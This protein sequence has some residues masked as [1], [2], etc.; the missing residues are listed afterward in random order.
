MAKTGHTTGKRQS[1]RPSLFIC[2]ARAS[3]HVLKSFFPVRSNNSKCLVFFFSYDW[4]LYIIHKC[5]VFAREIRSECSVK[6][7]PTAALNRQKNAEKAIPTYHEGAVL[8]GQPTDFC[9]VSMLSI[10]NERASLKTLLT[11][12]VFL[13]GQHTF[14]CTWDEKKYLKLVLS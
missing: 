8:K 13:I 4:M 9:G 5:L 7:Q 10:P 3:S 14:T 6:T 11:R 1:V 12:T 2:T